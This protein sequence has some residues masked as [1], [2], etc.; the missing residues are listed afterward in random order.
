MFVVVFM[1][2]TSIPFMKAKMIILLDSK[3][4]QVISCKRMQRRRKRHV[5]KVSK[6]TDARSKAAINLETKVDQVRPSV[7]KTSKTRKGR[8]TLRHDVRKQR[9]HSSVLQSCEKVKKRTRQRKAKTATAEAEKVT[10][11][12]CQ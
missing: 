10:K 11:K 9:L 6:T 7:S 4:F 12:A 2:K 1:Q 5:K 3:S 8:S